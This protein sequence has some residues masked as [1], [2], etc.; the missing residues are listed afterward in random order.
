MRYKRLVLVVPVLHVYSFNSKESK[1]F[2]PGYVLHGMLLRKATSL[3]QP[4]SCTGSSRQ[5]TSSFQS[6][7][8]QWSF[9]IV[10]WFVIYRWFMEAYFRFRIAF[11]LMLLRPSVLSSAE[12]ASMGLR[13]VNLTFGERLVCGFQSIER[14]YHDHPGNHP[15]LSETIRG[16]QTS[17]SRTGVS[18]SDLGN[19]EILAWL[20]LTVIEESTEWLLLGIGE[21]PWRKVQKSILENGGLWNQEQSRNL[22]RQYCMPFFDVFWRCSTTVCILCHSHFHFFQ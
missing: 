22:C 9:L 7:W 5:G 12:S 4:S 19:A 6:L 21:V 20:R 13:R 10:C 17:W 14:N 2:Y 18:V 8:L 15:W 11:Y 3:L 16:H 1:W